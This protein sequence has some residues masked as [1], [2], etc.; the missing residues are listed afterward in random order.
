M[1]SRYLM[2]M[3]LLLGSTICDLSVSANPLLRAK[4]GLVRVKRCEWYEERCTTNG[5]IGGGA[6]APSGDVDNEE[7]SDEDESNQKS[8]ESNEKQ[9]SNENGSNENSDES[10][11]NQGS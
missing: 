9:S 10:K 5:G 8:D 7:G 1:N 11:E 3:C 2:V 4:R 6:E